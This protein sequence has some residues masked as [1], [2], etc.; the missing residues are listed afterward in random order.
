M[1]SDVLLF[2]LGS[3]LWGAEQQCMNF[4]MHWPWKEKLTLWFVNPL[5]PVPESTGTEALPFTLQLAF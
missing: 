1:E 3:L 4:A 2:S 5:F